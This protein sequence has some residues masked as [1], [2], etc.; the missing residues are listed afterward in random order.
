VKC[1]LLGGLTVVAVLFGG[2]PGAGAERS[3]LVKARVFIIGGVRSFRH[4]V[5]VT[6]KDSSRRVMSVLVGHL[7]GLP[8]EPTSLRVPNGWQGRVLQ[9]HRR[10]WVAWAVK[11]SCLGDAQ[12]PEVPNAVQTGDLTECG[13]RDGE[14]LNFEFSLRYEA[15]ELQT[16]PIFIE[17]SDGR[18]GIASR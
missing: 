4:Q 18:T 7:P 8:A 10:G 3:P 15:E 13:L 6:S 11:V 9:R 12:L 1:K 14:T 16:E 5:T 2:A 17:F